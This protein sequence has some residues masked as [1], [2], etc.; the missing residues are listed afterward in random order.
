MLIKDQA[1]RY[2][3]LNAPERRNF[4]SAIIATVFGKVV[5]SGIF[6]LALLTLGFYTLSSSSV[7]ASP[8][9]FTH[10]Q[11]H[12][13]SPKGF[14]IEGT[15]PNTVHGVLH[16]GHTND[17]V[18]LEGRFSYKEKSDTIQYYFT[19]AAGDSIAVDISKSNN[20]T[21]PIPD[22]NY[23]LWGQVQQSIFSTSINVIEFT[24]MG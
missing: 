15:Q 10:N 1:H 2:K 12:R 14:G 9:G 7:Y 22:L 13:A 19:D 20:A 17:Y 18:V 16:N 11:I 23:Y 24:P 8:Q 6:L 4:V 21:P 3:E 5:L